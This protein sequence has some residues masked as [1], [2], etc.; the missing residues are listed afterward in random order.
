MTHGWWFLRVRVGSAARH[1][2]EHRVAAVFVE[3]PVR[4]LAERLADTEGGGGGAGG[5]ERVRPA[6]AGSALR[7]AWR[8]ARHSCASGG[9]N[10][11][12]LDMISCRE[13]CSAR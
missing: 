6:V 5:E 1:L 9:E 12:R 10:T 7:V 3:R 11:H 4:G 2:E 13:L 8:G